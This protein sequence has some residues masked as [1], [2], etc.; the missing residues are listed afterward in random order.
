MKK[1]DRDY[2]KF[3]FIIEVW[4]RDAELKLQC[5]V[6]PA[7]Y[8]GRWSSEEVRV[9]FSTDKLG[10][11]VIRGGGFSLSNL[12]FNSFMT[13]YDFLAKF[14]FKL[15]NIS[16]TMSQFKRVKKCVSHHQLYMFSF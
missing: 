1:Y 14:C 7:L 6:F 16:V 9:T 5:V 2:S 4:P 8:L 12:H 11:S 15:T 13:N 3:R 10:L